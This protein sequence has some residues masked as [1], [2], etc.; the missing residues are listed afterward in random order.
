[1]ACEAG[2]AAL[3]AEAASKGIRLSEHLDG[4]GVLAF[5][6]ACF[7]GLEGSSPSAGID[8]TD[9]AARR[10]GSRSKTQAHRQL[11]GSWNGSAQAPAR[12]ADDGDMRRLG[13]RNLIAFCLNDAC[14]HLALIDV[15]SQWGR[16]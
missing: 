5:Q 13:V 10:I 2:D 6:H 15:S 4:D 12:P 3:T 8:L 11:H 1:V 16:R 7:M 9:P 14:R